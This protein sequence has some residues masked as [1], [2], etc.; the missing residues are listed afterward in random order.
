LERGGAKS[1][2]R[3]HKEGWLAPYSRGFTLTELAITVSVIGILSVTLIIRAGNL[4][5]RAN[6][7][8]ARGN[9]GIIRM[10]IMAYY[11]SNGGQW[12]IQ[13]LSNSLIPNYV[14]E[15]PYL[16]LNGH[17]RTNQVVSP[18]ITDS[19]GWCYSSTTG[20]ICIDCTHL[21]LDGT[22]MSDW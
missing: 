5:R 14:N 2:P 21:G 18:D 8:A 4:I 17:S 3:M 16:N 12:P 9:L 13:P 10:A 22:Q 6:E 20:K 7:D 1:G 19:G 15:I 11:G